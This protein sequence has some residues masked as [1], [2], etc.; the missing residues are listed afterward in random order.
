MES[1]LELA[2]VQTELDNFKAVLRKTIAEREWLHCQHS[3]L[4]H[5]YQDSQD[6]IAEYQT[7]VKDLKEQLSVASMS[8]KCPHE[9]ARESANTPFPTGHSSA[10]RRS[11]SPATKTQTVF[12]PY[13]SLH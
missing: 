1:K 3:L 2:V 7:I 6:T 13:E 10:R 5:Q 8:R 4:Q 12:N 11:R 9:K